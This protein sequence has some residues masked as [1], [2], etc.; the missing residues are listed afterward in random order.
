M[1]A[2]QWWSSGEVQLCGGWR[3][4]EKIDGGKTWLLCSG[5]F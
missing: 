3:D 1:A 4:G 2:K 5:D